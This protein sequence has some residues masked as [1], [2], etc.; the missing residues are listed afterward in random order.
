MMATDVGPPQWFLDC[1]NI[2]EALAEK[3]GVLLVTNVQGKTHPVDDYESDSIITE[4]L[5]ATELD[6]L[7]RAFE[8]AGIYCEVILDEDG[9]LRWLDTGKATFPRPYVLVYNLA[10]NGTGPARLSLVPGL[11]RLHH[12]PLIDSDAYAVS[13]ARHKFHSA[14]ILRQCGLTAARSWWYAKWGWWPGPP[15]MGLRLIAKPTYESASIG[16]HEDSV[17]VMGD[18]VTEKLEATLSTYRQPLTVQEFVHGFEVEVPVLDPGGPRALSAVGIELDG[19]RD[20]NDAFLMYGEVADDHYTF[21]DFADENPI[22]AEEALR[23]A[24]KAFRG[25]GLAG[26][27]RI[28]FRVPIEG[29]PVIIEVACKPHLTKHS[30]FAYAVSRF[31]RAHED[32]L[33]FLVGAAAVRHGLKP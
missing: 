26:A 13:L 10:Q 14:T 24:R 9:F 1:V 27:G 12:L 7:I 2:A 19:R 30:S 4:F 17:F 15:P 3:V 23:A 18:D 21:Y 5:K 11:C 16:I 33:K 6:D 25:L 20:L 22:T 8:S 32:L 29:P 31:G 28:D